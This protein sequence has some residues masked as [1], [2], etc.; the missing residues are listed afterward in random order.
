MGNGNSKI[1]LSLNG[2]IIIGQFIAPFCLANMPTP[3]AYCRG[4]VSFCP[5]TTTTTE[6]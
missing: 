4:V 5:P 3:S 2:N 6:I 1:D